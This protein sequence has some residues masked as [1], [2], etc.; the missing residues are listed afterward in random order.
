[1]AT[2]TITEILGGDNIAGSRI[3][4]NDNFKKLAASINTIE[5]YIDTSFTPGAAL[6]VGSALVKKYSRA[7]TDQIFTCEATG[8]VGGNLNVGQDLSVTRDGSFTRNLTTHGNVSFDGTASTASTLSASIPFMLNAAI[9]S[10]QYYAAA[11]SN[12]LIINPQNLNTPSSTAVTR[13]IQAT[14]SFSKVS[15]IRLDWSTY[16]GSSTFTCK[17]VILPAVS[18][19]NVTNGQVITVIV[20]NPAPSG[21]TGVDLQIATDT[22]DGGIGGTYASVKFNDN[23]VIQSDSPKL[24][25]AMITFIADSNGWR[26]L[27]A[28]GATVKIS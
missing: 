13:Q 8:L 25:Q 3:T 4:I 7:I 26:I 16:T 27:H 2:I 5:T 14:A 12:S 17:N 10:P 11:T 15:V 23:T 20:D 21:T 6:N 9:S 18:N 1:M 28:V 22:L 24:R 19:A